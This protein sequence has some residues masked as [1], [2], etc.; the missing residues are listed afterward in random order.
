[1]K[2]VLTTPAY[3]DG[4]PEATKSYW[5]NTANQYNVIVCTHR[6]NLNKYRGG[7]KVRRCST[8]GKYGQSTDVVGLNLDALLAK[9]FVLRTYIPFVERL[10]GK[11]GNVYSNDNH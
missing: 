10:Q 9:G 4:L 11:R 3:W 7:T 5:Q 2:Q 1:M 8:G 6:P